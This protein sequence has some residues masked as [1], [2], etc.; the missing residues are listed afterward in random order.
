MMA[1]I[2]TPNQR[3]LSWWHQCCSLPM[4][5]VGQFLPN[6]SWIS[7]KSGI[8]L[9]SF[10]PSSYYW[11]LF[12]VSF[13]AQ[14]A[15]SA[16]PGGSWWEVPVEREEAGLLQEVPPPASALL[17][18]DEALFFLAHWLHLCVGWVTRPPAKFHGWPPARTSLQGWRGHVG[19]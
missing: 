8:S 16:D 17:G 9:Q 4:S 15:N 3:W 7:G 13:S 14:W 1:A 18:L 6:S 5:P 2:Q 10:L 19:G 11:L 12:P